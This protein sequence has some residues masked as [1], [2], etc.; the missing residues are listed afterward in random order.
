MGQFV[1]LSVH[2]WKRR[3]VCGGGVHDVLIALRCCCCCCLDA[4][5]DDDDDDDDSCSDVHEAFQ[6]EALIHETEAGVSG[7]PRRPR[8]RG[9]TSG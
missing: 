5:D 3:P 4:D 7:A 1:T 9:H 8:D 6:A 2:I